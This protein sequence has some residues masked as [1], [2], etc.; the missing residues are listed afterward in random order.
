MATPF[1]HIADNY[2]RVFTNSIVGQLQRRQVWHYLE[3]MLPQLDGLEILELNCGTGEDAVLFGEKGF[4]VIATDVSNE[5]L[6]ATEIKAH[7]LSMQHRVTSRYLDLEN[8]SDILFD[9]KFDLIFSNFGGLNCIS[10]DAMQKLLKRLPLLLTPNGRFIG[11][12]MPKF[13]LWEFCYFLGKFQFGKI[14]R[15]WTSQGVIADLKGSEVRTWYYW[16]GQIESWSIAGFKIRNV[17]PIGLALP[18]SYLNRFFEKR[19]KMLRGLNWM[20]Q[21]LSTTGFFSRVSDHFIID[22]QLR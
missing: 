14:F 18:P 12:L 1:D 15:R 4:N 2:D 3:S 6:K 19:R 13:C 5:M 21:R 7:R 20:E 17:R 10:P 22:L 16:P 11:V 8:F 9:K